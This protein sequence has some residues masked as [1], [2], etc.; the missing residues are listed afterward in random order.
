MSDNSVQ[1]ET[2]TRGAKLARRLALAGA[3]LVA[4]LLLLALLLPLLVDAGRY[5]ERINAMA[6]EAT[7]REVMLGGEMSLRLLPS[8]AL[9]VA[10]VT[11]A[12]LA[13]GEAPWFARLGRLDIVLALL[14]LLHGEIRVRRIELIEPDIRLETLADGRVNWQFVPA[15][16]EDDAGSAPR[17]IDLENVVVRRGRLAHA[18]LASG[19]S[20]VLEDIDARLVARLP[21][22]PFEAEAS[23]RSAGVALALDLESRELAQGVR[24]PLNLAFG[25]GKARIALNGHVRRGPAGTLPGA[26][27]KFELAGPSLAALL[28]DAARLVGE[29][30]PDTTGLDRPFS[31]ASTVTLD[32]VLELAGIAG[33]LGETTISG[34]ARLDPDGGPEIAVDL[35]ADRLVLD[36]FLGDG[37]GEA[38]DGTPATTFTVGDSLLPPAMKLDLALALD[39]L[40]WRDSTAS[41]LRLRVA[42]KDG[43]IELLE[44]GG[45]TPGAGKVALT[46]EVVARN[47]MPHFSGRL[48]ADAGNLP[49]LLAWLGVGDR[50]AGDEVF[51]F[52]VG[53][54]FELDPDRLAL[55]GLD[56]RVDRT[57]LGGDLAIAR[58][59]AGLRLDA[60]LELDR[61]DLDRWLPA[62]P[63]AP[64]PAIA[65]LAAELDRLLVAG[66]PHSAQLALR[67]GRIDFAGNPYQEVRLQAAASAGTLTIEEARIGKLPGGSVFLAGR[68]GAHTGEGEGPDFDLALRLAVDEPEVL[69]RAFDLTLPV[70]SAAL[71]PMNLEGTVAGSPASVRLDLAAGIAGGRLTA[72][73]TLAQP[74]AATPGPIDLA[75][76]F[77][78]P[79]HRALAQRLN[80][81]A[82]AGGEA[83]PLRLSARLGGDATA[84]ALHLDGEALGGS[85]RLDGEIAEPYGAARQGFAVAA[86]HPS[87]DR[88]L[89][90]FAPTRPPRPDPARAFSLAARYTGTGSSFTLADIA[91]RAGRSELGG[92]VELDTAGAR[93]RFGAELVGK[94][95]DLA[96][97]LVPETSGVVAAQA[98]AGERW[99]R[100]PF[101][102][103]GLRA[104]DG[105]LRLRAGRLIDAPWQID[106]LDLGLAL[107]DGV[108]TIERLDG[109]LY[110]GK[111][112]AS[113]R[114]D[115]RDLPALEL[116]LDLS[117]TA[118]GPLLMAASG[119]DV[120]SGKLDLSGSFKSRGA[121]QFAM[122]SNLSGAARLA[123]RDGAL[124]GIDLPR[125]AT[126]MGQLGRTAELPGLFG[127]ALSGGRTPFGSASVSLR[128]AEGRLSGEDLALRQDSY[129]LRAG[130]AIDLAAWSVNGKGEVTFPGLREAPPLGLA[131]MGNLAAPRLLFEDAPLRSWLARRIAGAALQRIPL[132]D[133][134]PDTPDIVGADSE[135]PAAEQTPPA[136]VMQRFLDA[137]RKPATK[138]EP[139]GKNPQD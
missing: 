79:S 66:R 36:D 59:G 93:P 74:V 50:V 47:R 135:A 96:D 114:L 33:K 20:F 71:A 1:D 124:E 38:H 100:T 104:T 41:R 35:R 106:A 7:G 133:R 55:S 44:A 80:L 110:G 39:A 37:A 130:G 137:V 118:L 19:K 40:R 9:R 99:S 117:D 132:P 82:L 8:P 85:F 105:I 14:P 76:G 12:N 10:D 112:A 48:E 46:G 73:G 92:R 129:E 42:G 69:A 24:A 134:L 102:L 88:L 122:I 60:D 57:R 26:G 63:D 11:L 17:Q 101:A 83:L 5:R 6:V 108:L 13:D 25:I 98:P 125:L 51:G 81:D 77:A 15:S 136:G 86:D 90:Q 84:F 139:D 70:T 75:L 16:V 68:L 4:L 64:P 3:G 113:G 107:A 119:L 94:T 31:L 49:A 67:A 65:D 62:D 45:Q 22:G 28:A 126:R 29:L 123:A 27:G 87:F 128:A 32:G 54:G 116:R 61:L 131:L 111:L 120:G 43:V 52:A 34:S 97:F 56:L 58:A 23:A 95:I 30:V 109:G 127:A 138:P 53:T 21:Y 115:A 89:R 103:D 2:M 91:L 78:H 18:D 72:R 121:S